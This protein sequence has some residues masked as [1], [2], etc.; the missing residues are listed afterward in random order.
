[1][2]VVVLESKDNFEH[3]TD[4]SVLVGKTFE[5][6]E[7]LLGYKIPLKNILEAGVKE[8]DLHKNNDIA[9]DTTEMFFTLE[10]VRRT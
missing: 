4:L 3:N 7:W 2:K 10:E 8:E 9:E 6:R 5:A 1:M